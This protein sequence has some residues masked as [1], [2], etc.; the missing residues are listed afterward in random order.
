MTRE[1]LATAIGDKE[2]V[3]FYCTGMERAY[4]AI[5][6]ARTMGNIGRDVLVQEW[7]RRVEDI[8]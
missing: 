3:V 7:L 1:N 2:I 4:H 5:K 6:Q 8:R